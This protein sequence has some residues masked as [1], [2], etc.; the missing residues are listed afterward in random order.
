MQELQADFVYIQEREHQRGNNKI[1]KFQLKIF[2]LTNELEA[3][4]MQIKTNK[5]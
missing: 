4:L 5:K 2:W 3:N 1:G